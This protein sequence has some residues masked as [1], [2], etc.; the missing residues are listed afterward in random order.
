MGIE[1]K[2]RTFYWYC[3]LVTILILFAGTS[4]S[5]ASPL[6][7][8]LT[9]NHTSGSAPFSVGFTDE[10]TG[11]A[12][13]GWTWYFGDEGYTQP[14]TLMNASGGW[15]V[16][17]KYA[18]VSTTN[19]SIVLMGGQTPG[20]PGIYNFVNDTWRSTDRGA[21]WTQ[22]NTSSGW[23]PRRY[24][25]AVAMA[26]GSI[27]LTGGGCET[28]VQEFGFTDTWRSTDNG[29]HWTL[30][31][32]DSGWGGRYGHTTVTLPDGSIVLIAGY[33]PYSSMNDV[34]RSTNNGLTWTQRNASAFPERYL[35]ASVALSDGTIV[36]TGGYNGLNDLNDT[37]KSTDNGLTWTLANA[38]SGWQVRERHGMVAMPDDSILLMGGTNS[39]STTFYNDIWRSTDK[40]A[41]WTR[42]NP[43]A[44]WVARA[45]FPCVVASDGSIVLIGGLADD[46]P[47]PPS[48]LPQTWRFQ[49][50]AGSLV[51]NPSHTYANSGVYQVALQV[52]NANSYNST[53]KAGYISVGVTTAPV[54]S[55]TSNT[56]S[57]TAPLAVNFT[58]TSSN[59]PTAWNWSFR[60]VTPGNNTQVWFSTVQSPTHTFDVGNYSIVLNASNSAGFNLSTQVTFINVT[61]TTVNVPSKIGIFRPS[62]GIWS[63]DSNGNF[64]WEGSDVSLSWGLPNDIPVIGD[65]NG[66]NRDDIGIFRPSSGIWSLDSNGNFAWE[67][68]DVSLSWGL[69][70]DKPVVGKY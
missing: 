63:L 67:G 28:A 39:T 57:G 60:N 44:Q 15:A 25:S 4:V 53:R 41:T 35:H 38:S 17:E 49:Q 10:T 69:P 8:G 14:W 29:A 54:A 11:E 50:P 31:N 42:V 48:P 7:V 19:G 34:W 16:R 1:K 64:A 12:P 55:F 13:T 33:V 52:Y 68:S 46:F 2:G 21:T 65:W 18:G 6:I 24:L 61:A 22:V 5:A 32:A 47:N 58:D 27:V 37:W 20:S 66:D 40:G 9:A 30:M 56:T 70:N 3:T 45:A 43:N 26:D 51:Q 62:S 36:V 59:T 23:S